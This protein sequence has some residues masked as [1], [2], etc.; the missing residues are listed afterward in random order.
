MVQQSS[1]KYLYTEVYV[2]GSDT[3]GQLGLELQHRTNT[4]N[5][6]SLPKSCSF[7]VLIKQV[8]CGAHHTAMLTSSGHL[9]MMGQN[10]YGQLGINSNND[11]YARRN[12]S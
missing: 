9:Y 10:N 7:N 6:Y 2:W 3:C 11:N 4:N 5:F 1:E 12:D 8:A